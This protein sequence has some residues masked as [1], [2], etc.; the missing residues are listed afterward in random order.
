MTE[1]NAKSGIAIL[2]DQVKNGIF[3][4]IGLTL[5]DLVFL[6]SDG[7]GALFFIAW[8][9]AVGIGVIIF[10][11]IPQVVLS[12]I[13]F[14]ITILLYFDA[15]TNKVDKFFFYFSTL[16]GAIINLGILLATYQILQQYGQLGLL[17]FF[18]FENPFGIH[19]FAYY[20][21]I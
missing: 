21:D 7:S 14:L 20:V 16:V 10:L 3:Y 2:F 11:S 18:P 19:N 1:V 12:L 8:I 6:F 5:A 13:T 15:M 17:E 9:V 4:G